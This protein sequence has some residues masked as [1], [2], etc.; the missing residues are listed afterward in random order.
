MLVS[1]AFLSSISVVICFIDNLPNDEI[2][3]AL[4]VAILPLFY[5]LGAYLLSLPIKARLRRIVIK[6]R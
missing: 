4:A 2:F 1:S 5:G 3:I 6:I